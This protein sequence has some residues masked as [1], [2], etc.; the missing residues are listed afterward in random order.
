MKEE[1]AKSDEGDR[2][3]SK[4]MEKDSCNSKDFEWVVP[5]VELDWMCQ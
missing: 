4:Y 3:Q 1:G 5:C 2:P